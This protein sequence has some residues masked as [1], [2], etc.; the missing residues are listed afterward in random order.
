M[1]SQS[2]TPQPQQIKRSYSSDTRP[3]PGQLQV[4]QLPTIPGSPHHSA[5]EESGTPNSR[6]SSGSG[7]SR[8]SENGVSRNRSKN[9]SYVPMTPPNQP[10]SLRGAAEFISQSPPSPTLPR[11][12]P[13]SPFTPNRKTRERRS[14][15]D[16]GHSRKL[17]DE[18]AGKRVIPDVPRLDLSLKV[19]KNFGVGTGSPV[20]PKSKVPPSPSRPIPPTPIRG[21]DIS[22]PVLDYGLLFS[23]SVGYLLVD[24]D[25]ILGFVQLQLYL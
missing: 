10:Q 22:G 20:T 18:D 3:K 13:T 14:A 12:G 4:N 2:Q 25:W 19:T 5:A 9:S 11:S 17:V 1:K 6:K 15:S 8:K 7:K 23:R 21:R 24:W 16:S